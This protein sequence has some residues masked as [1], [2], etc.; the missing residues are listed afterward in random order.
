[1]IDSIE[2]KPF[3]RNKGRTLPKG[4]HSGFVERLMELREEV[5]ISQEALSQK[6]GLSKSTYGTYE[7][8]KALPDAETVRNLAKYYCVS[9]DYLLGITDER[10]KEPGDE[11]SDIGDDSIIMKQFSYECR[12]KFVDV[13]YEMPIKN[14]FENLVREKEFVAFLAYVYTY[15]K[16]SADVQTDLIKALKSNNLYDAVFSVDPTYN[17]LGLT[18][19]VTSKPSIADVYYGMLHETLDKMLKNLRKNPV[20]ISEMERIIR[21][22][23][24]DDEGIFRE[25]KHE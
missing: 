8:D 25:I 1:M 9:A 5:G 3:F 22:V 16:Y 2:E 11:D 17:T 24:S 15:V 7:I 14:I 21:D 19:N 23:Y 18:G 6:I 12:Q 4:E 10:D 20:Y 13:L